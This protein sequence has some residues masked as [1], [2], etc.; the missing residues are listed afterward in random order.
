MRRI[1][2]AACSLMLLAAASAP[3]MAQGNMGGGMGTDPAQ[4]LQRSTDRLLT[5]ITLS[6]SQTDSVKAVNTRFAA[7]MHTEMAAGGDMRAQMTAMRTKQRADIRAVL[8]ADQQV[9]FDKNV[10]D[11]EKARMSRPQP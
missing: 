11:M 4:M 9:V 10:A 1:S 7:S 5:G 2:I 3:A 6:A 8:T